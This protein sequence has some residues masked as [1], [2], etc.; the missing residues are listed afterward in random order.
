M[1]RRQQYSQSHSNPVPTQQAAQYGTLSHTDDIID[2]HGIALEQLVDVAYKLYDRGEANKEKVFQLQLAG[3]AD[4]QNVTSK[5]RHIVES[6]LKRVEESLEPFRE[7]KNFHEAGNQVLSSYMEYITNPAR[8]AAI[9]GKERMMADMKLITEGKAYENMPQTYRDKALR[10]MQSDGVDVPIT[11]NEDGSISGGYM[12]YTPAPYVSA[13]DVLKDILSDMGNF[14]DS[15]SSTGTSGIGGASAGDLM[16]SPFLQTYTQ[17]VTGLS[18]DRMA[19]VIYPT[20]MNHQGYKDWLETK[21]FLDNVD[22][23]TGQFSPITERD[24][25]GN[26][27]MFK[28]NKNGSKRTPEELEAEGMFLLEGAVDNL[29][30]TLKYEEGTEI[31]DEDALRIIHK[32]AF[33]EREIQQAAAPYMAKYIHK[34][35]EVSSTISANNAYSQMMKIREEEKKNWLVNAFYADS[36]GS[37]FI[38]SEAIKEISQLEEQFKIAEKLAINY[39]NSQSHLSHAEI[40]NSPEFKR[41]L[42]TQKEIERQLSEKKQVI[43]SVFDG[44]N[45][46][47]Y[48]QFFDI[49]R[50]SKKDREDYKIIL[51]SGNIENINR[52]LRH[53][54]GTPVKQIFGLLSP[55]VGIGIGLNRQQRVNDWFA[56]RLNDTMQ[57]S[58]IQP[59]HDDGTFAQHL[60]AI[61]TYIDKGGAVEFKHSSKYKTNKDIP[62]HY[63]LSSVDLANVAGDYTSNLMLWYQNSNNPDDKFSVIGSSPLINEITPQFLHNIQRNQNPAYFAT[64]A[65]TDHFSQAYFSNS[66]P[67]GIFSNGQFNKNNTLANVLSGRILRD[68]GINEVFKFNVELPEFNEIGQMT[69][70]ASYPD[71][72]IKRNY[73]KTFTFSFELESNNLPVTRTYNQPMDALND[74]LSI[75]NFY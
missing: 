63:T 37:N 22:P 50:V 32:Q 73:D 12:G 5:N 38:F 67:I 15:H 21:Y 1:Y 28:E 47:E 53:S 45:D 9:V 49:N 74:I 43:F 41:L 29:K 69:G 42:A 11:V 65:V 66:V 60:G 46:V 27:I 23:N 71:I 20:L 54:V 68:L 64:N 34:Q 19:A 39:Y 52:V 2:D 7:G 35:T 57:V 8:N 75:Y 36:P 51:Q 3:I 30:R 70:N 58:V 26:F 6:S 40:G 56:D 24:V 33:A 59:I 48:E 25:V 31:T 72:I 61:R 17:K 14:K 10:F 18:E 55:G 13:Q 44:M 4:M 16:N 62:N